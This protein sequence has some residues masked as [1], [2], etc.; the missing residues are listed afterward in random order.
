MANFRWTDESYNEAAQ[1][2]SEF[3]EDVYH[4]CTDDSTSTITKNKIVYR[5][6]QANYALDFMDAI[7]KQQ[8]LLIQA[9][10]GIGKSYGYLLPTFFTYDSV[11]KFQK[12][13]ISTSSIALQDQLLKDIKKISE[14]LNIKIN[15]EIAKGINN[16]ACLEKIYKEIVSG[17]SDEATKN[18]LRNLSSEMRR[19]ESSDRADL[20]PLSE[21]IWNKIRLQNRGKCSHC[22]YSKKCLFLQHQKDITASNIVITNHAYLSSNPSL[23]ADAN[24]LIVDEAHKLEENMRDIGT[25]E[26]DL[27]K[28]KNLI[29]TVSK[30]IV[31]RYY[32]NSIQPLYDDESAYIGR[33][34]RI[35][36]KALEKLFNSIMRTASKNFFVS[37]NKTGNDYS[38][39]DSNRLGFRITARVNE[40]LDM[41]L[42]ELNSL[43]SEIN[44][45]ERNTNTKLDNKVI[46]RLNQ[47]KLMLED[48]KLGPNSTNIYWADF[49]KENK[50]RI[51]C[52][53]KNNYNIAKLLFSKEIPILFTSGTM[54]DAEGNYDHFIDGIGLK[55]FNRSIVLGE[56]QPSPYDYDN[57]ARFYYNPNIANPN[58]ETK[59]IKDLAI[60]ISE[61]IRATNG[62]ALVLFTS[63]RT[64]NS[65]YQLLSQEEFPFKLLLQTDTNTNE[66]K[67]H[68]SSDIDSCLFATGAFWEGIDIKGQSLSNLI[69][70]RLPFAQV[71]A[72]TQEKA[73][74]YAES[75]QFKQVYF[76]DMLT[77]LQQAIGRL[78]RSDTDTGIVCCLDSRITN[79]IHAIAP[80]IPIR[81]FI[82][83][84]KEL[85]QFIDNKILGIEDKNIKT[86]K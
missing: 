85:Y 49:Y 82:T 68:F 64:M 74:T 5:E 55:G 77:K 28:I 60:E 78:I 72:V 69:I 33:N 36:F 61:L 37:N 7:K 39:T 73:R 38:V 29:E 21:N 43:F 9:G 83:D 47:L 46:N 44:I 41:S 45:Y 71:D 23:I 76:P 26:F 59:Y 20:R 3:F 84:K 53:P 66:I 35:I 13:I 10:V 15:V 11:Q 6:G 40:Y 24:L 50:I 63:K 19:I 80:N 14:M 70:T 12:V 51:L 18:I 52:A 17:F 58:D 79:Y 1:K 48:M 75:E 86:L 54:L 32:N 57:N 22:S 30:L 81:N 25:L 4:Q 27:E 31:Y 42:A 62:K 16:Y 34:N 56:E 8:I 67:E 65:V 2:L